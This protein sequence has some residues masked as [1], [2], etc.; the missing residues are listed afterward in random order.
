MSKI[1]KQP[2]AEQWADQIR[3][4]LGKSVESI[5]AVGRLL[6]KAKADLVHGEWGRMFNDELIPFGP[7]TAQRLMA[8]A[9][10]PELSNTAHAP[11]LPP[12]W[13]SLYELTKVE[14]ERLH[15]AFK[16]RIITPDMKRS[17][18]AALLAPKATA[19]R[20]AEA[21][22]DAEVTDRS[23]VVTVGHCPISEQQDGEAL[24]DAETFEA[25]EGLIVSTFEVLDE[26]QRDP[27][28]KRLRQLIDRLG[29]K[30]QEQ[31]L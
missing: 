7:N 5:I 9:A 29:L 21:I 10:N 3:T 28:L 18:V 1:S 31:P 23:T 20:A 2:R 13:T 17:D 24:S 11:F 14:P 22:I 4:Q 19:V 25:V 26:N 6:T 27:F 8:I 12:S 16:D 30:L 15:G